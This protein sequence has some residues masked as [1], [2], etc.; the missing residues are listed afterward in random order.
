MRLLIYALMIFENYKRPT[1]LDKLII[2]VYQFDHVTKKQGIMQVDTK[3]F[4]AMLK[5]L[6]LLRKS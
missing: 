2:F 5:V 6:N 3:G 4:L 1:F